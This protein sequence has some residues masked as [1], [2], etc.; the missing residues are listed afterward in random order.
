MAGGKKRVV[1]VL[2]MDSDNYEYIKHL[3]KEV[4]EAELST[5][6]LHFLNYKSF[7]IYSYED[8]IARLKRKLR[9]KGQ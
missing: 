2:D 8:F 6:L 3:E 7:S 4:A 9:I 1:I 5:Y